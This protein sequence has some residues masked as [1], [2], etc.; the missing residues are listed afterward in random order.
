VTGH[1]P[2]DATLLPTASGVSDAALATVLEAGIRWP[3]VEPDEQAWPPVGET[4]R[5]TALWDGDGVV[6]IVLESPEPLFRAGRLALTG[7]SGF[8]VAVRDRSGCRV[9]FCTPTPLP[10][11]RTVQ[12]GRNENG[13]PQPDLPCALPKGWR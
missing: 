1:L 4:G 6:G 11:P 8:P 3:G 2:V 12:L 9:L 7:L 13:V 10:G 5:S